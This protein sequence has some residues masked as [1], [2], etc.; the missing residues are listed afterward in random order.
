MDLWPYT[1]HIWPIPYSIGNSVS[2]GH[3]EGVPFLNSSN[4]MSLA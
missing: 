2:S 1:M 4:G 3:I